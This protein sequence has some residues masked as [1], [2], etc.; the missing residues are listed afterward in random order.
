MMNKKENKQFNSLNM[1]CGILFILFI[2]MGAFSGYQYNRSYV[3]YLEGV[4]SVSTDKE[5]C[6]LL[7]SSMD[8]DYCIRKAKSVINLTQWYSHYYECSWI[9][10]RIDSQFKNIDFMGKVTRVQT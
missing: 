8:G 3:S 1:L 5:M 2:F 7:N 6:K 4:Y 10:I 9:K